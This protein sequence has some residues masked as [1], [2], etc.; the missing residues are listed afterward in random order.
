[1][2]SVYS[3]LVALVFLV[4]F[5]R[6][7]IADPGTTWENVIFNGPDRFEVLQVFGDLAVFDKETGRVWEQSPS[8]GNVVWVD[9]I[10]HCYN[11]QVNARMG[12]RLP[13]IEELASLVD[14]SQQQPALPAGHPFQ[15]VSLFSYWSATTD[16]NDNSNAWTVAFGGRGGLSNQS[17]KTDPAL[18]WCVRGGQ[19]ID[20]VWVR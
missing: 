14:P 10:S 19:G 13:T 8:Q 3:S 1:M 5:A 7:A 6:L 2:K 11:L 15:N 17:S 20:G 16:A 12:W 4:V 18:V 9:A